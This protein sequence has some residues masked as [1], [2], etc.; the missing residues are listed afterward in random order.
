ML[1]TQRQ[2]ELKPIID[3]WERVDIPVPH[4]KD[5]YQWWV[6]Y[7]DNGSLPFDG[8]WMSQPEWLHEDFNYFNLM[9]EWHS[10]PYKIKDAQEN[11]ND[12]LKRG[13]R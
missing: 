4:H 8:N 13:N 12:V 10:L 2:R 6:Q 7:C 1:Y 5:S 9:D 3:E 11:I